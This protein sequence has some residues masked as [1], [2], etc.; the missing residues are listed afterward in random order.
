[1]QETPASPGFCAM[2]AP[3]SAGASAYGARR[4]RLRGLTHAAELSQVPLLAEVGFGP[5]WEKAH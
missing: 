2:K 5:N 1:M 4:A 3:I